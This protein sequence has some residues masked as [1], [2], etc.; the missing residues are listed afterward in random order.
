MPF[1]ME[2]CFSDQE[3]PPEQ[4]KQT[5][6]KP[7]QHHSPPASLDTGQAGPVFTG[8][9]THTHKYKDREISTAKY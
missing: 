5:V 4:T 7:A 8:K 2:Y 9:T 1:S 3:P 6:Y